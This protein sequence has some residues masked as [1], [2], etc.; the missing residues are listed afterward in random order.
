MTLSRWLFAG[1]MTVSVSSAWIFEARSAQDSS[2]QPP[3][4]PASKPASKPSTKPARARLPK[5]FAAKK[6]TMPD[7]SVRKYAIFIPPQYPLYESNKWPLIVALHGSAEVGED[8]VKQTTVGL[9]PYIVSRTK[10]FPFIAVFPQA[11]QMWFRGPEEAAVWKIMEATIREYRVDPDRIYLT[12]LSMG[13]FATWEMGAARPDVFAA[14]VPVCGAG[15]KGYMS[16]LVDMPI[17]AFHGA[18]DANVPVARSR[19][20]IEE[21][22]SLGAKPRYTEYPD[23]AHE[24]WNQAYATPDLWRWLLKQRRRPSP[25]VIDYLLCGS[26]VQVWWFAAQADPAAKSP[27]HVHAEVTQNGRLTIDTTDVI[28]WMVLPGPE[29]LK[30]G[31]EIEAFWN[32]KEIY[33]GEFHGAIGV[34]P[35][36]TSRPSSEPAGDPVDEPASRPDENG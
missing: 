20:L 28:A 1:M 32:G 21:L 35:E 24:S 29:P 11:H 36:P 13:G 3:S 6:I 26:Q 10:Q 15:P 19:E 22:K 31:E 7:G 17:W 16:N 4:Q 12:G 25:R 33:K 5:G 30:P 8:G 9:A 23:V 14:L 2:S 18:V 27:P 34:K